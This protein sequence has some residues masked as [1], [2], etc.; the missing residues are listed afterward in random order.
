M[1]ISK[2][3]TFVSAVL[4]TVGVLLALSV[5][6]PNGQW[7]ALAAL[8]VGAQLICTAFLSTLRR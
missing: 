2:L 6:A 1:N 3:L 7:I 5:L 8:V 4:G